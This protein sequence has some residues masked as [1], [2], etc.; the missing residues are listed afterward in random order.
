MRTAA[1]TLAELAAEASRQ[2]GSPVTYTD[3]DAEQLAGILTGA[4]LPAGLVAVLVDA[5][6]HTRT[7]ALAT[8]TDDLRTLL[9]RPTTTLAEA[10]AEALSHV[11]RLPAGGGT[12]SRARRLPEGLAAEAAPVHVPC[13]SPRANAT[14]PR[15]RPP[16]TGQPQLVPHPRPDSVYARSLRLPCSDRLGRFRKAE[17]WDVSHRP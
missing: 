16:A 6:T 1:W 14:S 2:S 15:H 3:V 9:G 12:H 4:G 5:E 13:S 17:R 11:C 8:V 7:G 10:V